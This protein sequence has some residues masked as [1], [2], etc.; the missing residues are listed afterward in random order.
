MPVQVT[1]TL[2]NVCKP[3]HL[4][5]LLVKFQV[6]LIIAM[7]CAQLEMDI[8]LKMLV[9]LLDNRHFLQL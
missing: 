4:D 8:W 2:S 6:H 3:L 1:P 9:K 5:N 7:S